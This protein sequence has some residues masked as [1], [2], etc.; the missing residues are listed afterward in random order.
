MRDVRQVAVLTLAIGLTACACVQV[1]SGYALGPE[2]NGATTTVPVGSELR[3]TLP[4]E[5]D[6]KVESTNTSALAL[7]STLI[8]SEGGVAMRGWLFY[9]KSACEFVLLVI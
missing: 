4:A 9:S 2:N 1:Q 3:L 8:G 7:K 5:Y 6:W